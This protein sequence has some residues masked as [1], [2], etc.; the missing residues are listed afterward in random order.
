MARTI[1]LVLGTAAVVLLV[2]RFVDSG[3]DRTPASGTRVLAVGDEAPA[4][5]LTDHEGRQVD[6]GGATG[7]WRIVSFFR[8]AGSPW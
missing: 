6:V 7:R 4:F 3:E 2:M 1:A 5:Q 8:Q